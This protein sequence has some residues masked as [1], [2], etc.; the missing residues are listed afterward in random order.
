MVYVIPPGRQNRE[1]VTTLITLVPNVWLGVLFFIQL[2]HT[3]YKG[4][5]LTSP[6]V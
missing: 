6:N 1:I 5:N 4:A 2:R 3:V